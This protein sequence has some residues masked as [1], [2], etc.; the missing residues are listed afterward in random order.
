MMDWLVEHGWDL[1]AAVGLL[2]LG[3]CVVGFGLASGLQLFA[4]LW[5]GADDG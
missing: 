4:A 3:S 1:V 5:P 2:T